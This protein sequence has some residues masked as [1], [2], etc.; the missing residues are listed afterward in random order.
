MMHVA[1]GNMGEDLG[2]EKGERSRS[3]QDIAAS[4]GSILQAAREQDMDIN[5]PTIE[6]PDEVFKRAD[7]IYQDIKPK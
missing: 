4:L 3:L 5:V 6:L 1:G 7:E 2:G